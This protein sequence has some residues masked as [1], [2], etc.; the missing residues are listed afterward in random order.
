MNEVPMELFSDEGNNA[1]L[2]LPGRQYPGVLIQGD[3]LHG[4]V[5][6]L[7]EAISALERKEFAEAEEVIRHLEVEFREVQSR[8]ESAV[9]RG[10]VPL[11]Y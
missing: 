6:R 8:Y 7:S 5:E 10:G 2:R 1:V 9:R 3:T 11:P 4:L